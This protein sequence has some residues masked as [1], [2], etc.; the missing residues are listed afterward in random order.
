[1]GGTHFPSPGKR[2]GCPVLQPQDKSFATPK[3]L[4]QPPVCSQFLAPSQFA[5]RQLCE[6]AKIPDLHRYR[7]VPAAGAL[8]APSVQFLVRQTLR[9]LYRS[10]PEAQA[11]KRRGR[12][13]RGGSLACNDKTFSRQHLPKSRDPLAPVTWDPPKKTSGSSLSLGGQIALASLRLPEAQ[14]R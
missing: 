3:L 14:P 13:R 5:K 8:S 2:Q 6:K 10:F 12:G 7:C 1:M 11:I 4:L 9:N